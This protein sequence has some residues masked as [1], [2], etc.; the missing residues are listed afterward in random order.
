MVP[1]AGQPRDGGQYDELT[2]A[3][4]AVVAGAWHADVPEDVYASWSAA[5]APDGQAVAFVSDRGGEPQVWVRRLAQPHPELVAAAPELVVSVSWSPDGEWLGCVTA[6]RAASRHQV[7]VLRPD[8]GDL[9]LV[10]GARSA[11]AVCGSGPRQGWSADGRLLLTETDEKSVALLVDP[12]NGDRRPLVT[13]SL[14]TLLDLSA[15]GRRAV[16]RRGPRSRRRLIVVDLATGRQCCLDTGT[17]SGSADHGCFSP[18]G[19]R[20]YA[21]SDVGRDFAALFAAAADG[22]GPARLLAARSG[23]D[24]QD[25]VV[26]PD[27]RTVALVWNV[28]GGLSALGVLDLDDGRECA[29]EPLPRAV[30][31]ECR[32]RPD[33]T[34]LVLTAESWSDPRGVWSLDL[35][36]PRAT[37]LSSRGSTTLWASRGATRPSVD[38]TTLTGP[39]PHRLRAADGLR[40]S[41]WLYRPH[42]RGPWPTVIYLHGGPEAQ[43]RPVY[44][45]LFQSLLATGLAVFAP[46]VRGSTGFGRAFGTA[47][48]REGRYAAIADVAACVDHLVGCGVAVAG[49]IGCAGR[50]YGGYLTLAALVWYPELFAV[51]V[52][53]CG[54]V[55]FATF[56]A[57]TEP[58]IAAAAVSKYGDP[59]EDAALLRDLSPLHRIDR[60][61][62][63]LLV[64]H[65]AHDTNV[66][67]QEAEQ[68]VA[69]LADRGVPHRYLLFDD[70]GHDLLA[71]ANRVTFVQETVAWLGDHLLGHRP[72]KE[73]PPATDQE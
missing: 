30:V 21:R 54:M 52:D 48:D 49:R 16:L 3:P 17:G 46:N 27:G 72:T 56:F 37:P 41:G 58:W 60:L 66:P 15:D 71:T 36:G 33:G 59:V 34:G 12:A 31:D 7:W 10:G 61:K 22:A 13:G 19:S 35:A 4:G 45:S 50:S 2:E 18:D 11:T 25:F 20:L 47:D 40:L 68:L 5:P 32:F 69:A 14:I 57:N 29:V 38:T 28:H 62:A 73:R 55:N 23:V 42:G 63:P 24:L 6:T 43:E 9:R 64:V 26:A 67:V 65:G 70:E 44:N 53:V 8:G 39:E 1:E 51:G